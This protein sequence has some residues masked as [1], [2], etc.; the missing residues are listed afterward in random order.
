MK[1]KF[2]VAV[3]ITLCLN[4]LLLTIAFQ[5]GWVKANPF[6]NV[7]RSGTPT[8]VSYQGNIWDGDSPYNG[9]GYFKFA[10]FD[11]ELNSVWSNDGNDEPIA[12]VP[13]TVNKG[14]FSVNLGDTNLS[15]MVEPLEANV[16]EDPDTILQVWFSP[17]GSHPWTRMPEQVIAAVPYALQS[18]LAVDALKV[19][20]YEASSFQLYVSGSCPA[21]SA[22]KDINSDGSVICEPVESKPRFSK[23]R[24]D[25]DNYV[26]EH[27]A[28]TIGTDGLGLISYMPFGGG[29]KVAHCENIACT[30]TT[31]S[32]I[33]LGNIGLRMSI[34]IGGDGL[35]LISY[36]DSE[37]MKLKIAHCN[38]I[39]CTGATVSEIAFVGHAEDKGTSITI[40]RNGYGL[41]SYYDAINKNLRLARCT[42]QLCSSSSTYL[43]DEPND[44][45]N[46]SSII[47]TSD[48]LYVLIAH[49]D[50]TNYDLRVSYFSL[51]SW[52][53]IGTTVL[54]SENNT[55]FYPSITNGVDGLAV[56]AY[57]DLSEN[58]LKVA[59]CLNKPCSEFTIVELYRR[60]SEGISI[61]IGSDNLP[62][63]SFID[64]SAN[65]LSI[66]KCTNLDCSSEPYYQFMLGD[67]GD[68]KSTSITIGL[69]GYPLI[70]F[71]DDTYG[72]LVV[73]HCSD[74]SCQP[75]YRRK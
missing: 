47:P 49:T 45:G 56:I 7:H 31:I 18:Q 23:T 54:D 51:A 71:Y 35:A 53:T 36:Y 32:V 72:D 41:I 55:G 38:D 42:N 10:I 14:F 26:G 60:P 48:S 61:N 5:A 43:V 62:V 68:S 21:G 70:S 63:I 29:L 37:F 74:T 27:N 59:H 57:A 11:S 24:V 16:F 50:L 4:I 64:L 25:S 20:G 3:A 15:G 33:D 39:A 30:E 9:T 69:D 8:I 52:S 58:S 34:A 65:Y 67:L 19:N 73:L 28:I 44:V 66:F 13:L 12:S 22:I 17:T 46:Y 2:G 1:Q 6:K 40:D 75:F